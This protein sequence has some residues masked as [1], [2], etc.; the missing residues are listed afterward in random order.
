[1]LVDWGYLTRGTCL[2]NAEACLGSLG[3]RTVMVI[4][5]V[6]LTGQWAVWIFGQ[7]L[8]HVFCEVFLD[9]INT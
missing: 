9:E 5:C 1:M 6:N 4:L 8:F 7:T 3:E 2:M